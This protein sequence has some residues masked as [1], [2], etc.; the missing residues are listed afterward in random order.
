M[1]EPSTKHWL[2]IAQRELAAGHAD[3]ARERAKRILA[4]EPGRVEALVLLANAHL[5]L[6]ELDEAIAVLEALDRAGLHGLGRA[7]ARAR[8]RRGARRLRA[9]DLAGA[10]EDLRRAVAMWPELVEAWFNLALLEQARG[11]PAAA[12][13]ACQEVLRRAPADAEA[14]LLAAE[15]EEDAPAAIDHLEKLPEGLPP[16]LRHSALRLVARLAAAD[17]PQPRAGDLLERMV[18]ADPALAEAEGAGL[19]LDGERRPARALL[20]SAGRRLAARGASGLAARLKAELALGAVPLDRAELAAWREAFA[21]GL[22]RLA[23]AQRDGELRALSLEDLGYAPFL[24]A[25]HGEDDRALLARLGDLLAD[26][27]RPLAPASPRDRSRGGRKVAMLSSFFR[28][29]TVGHY[30][31]S[32]PEALRRAGFELTLIQLGPRR[33]AMTERLAGRA[34]RF[35]FHREGPDAL[36]KWIADAGFDLLLYPELGMDERVFALAAL[37]LAPLQLCAWGHPMTSGLPTIDGFLSV[38]AMEP[39]DGAQH[40]RERLVLLPGIGTAYPRPPPAEPFD[41]EAFGLPRDAVLVFYPHSPFKIHPDDDDLLAELAASEAGL[42]F[43]LF[44][45]ERPSFRARLGDRLARALERRGLRAADRLI[46]LPLM[47]RPRYLAVAACCDFLLDCLRWSGGNTT[48]DALS[49]GLPV[50]TVPGRFMRGRQSA[51]MLRLLGADELIAPD[52]DALLALARRFAREPELRTAWRR[53]I[54]QAAGALYERDDT[55]PAL[56]AAL[57]E[58]WGRASP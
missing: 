38:A 23:E 36:A 6:D 44:E 40:Y 18:G 10:G 8:N 2:A 32:W 17:P 13:A 15:L 37:R 45:G 26:L 24:L 14:R 33:D 41:R 4:R 11:Q 55:G 34:D 58:W 21:D 51:A 57:E 39:P 16:A 29:C 7:L 50:L 12:R 1:T 20:A 31:A 52:R 35:L 56:A 5:A 46:W 28:D 9:G 3:R 53:R 54:A 43:V 19:A 22:T 42:R 47:P 25:Y 27:A 49:V 30:F 48:L